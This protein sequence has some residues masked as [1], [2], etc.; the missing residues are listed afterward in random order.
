MSAFP[1]SRIS[2]T[3]VKLLAQKQSLWSGEAHA[4]KK[5]MLFF[6]ARTPQRS[7]SLLLRLRLLDLE[8]SRSHLF[9]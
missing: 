3:F 6:L 4:V 7:K 1:P 8:D 2:T 9:S 5:Y